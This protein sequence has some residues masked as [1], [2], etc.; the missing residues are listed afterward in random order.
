V[1]TDV[2]VAVGG[3]PV[4]VGVGVGGTA[5][6]VGVAVAGMTVAVGVGVAV[7]VIVSVGVGLAVAV[8]VAVAVSVATGAPGV[9]VGGWISA[10]DETSSSATKATDTTN[11]DLSCFMLSTSS[12]DCSQKLDVHGIAVVPPAAIEQL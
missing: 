3:S 5:V 8:A 9:G 6:C 12:G 10:Q 7:T 4:L 2:G 11:R 1:G